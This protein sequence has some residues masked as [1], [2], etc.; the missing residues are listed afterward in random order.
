MALED[1]LS[2]IIYTVHVIIQ[3][4]II[5]SIGAQYTLHHYT[6]TLDLTGITQCSDDDSTSCTCLYGFQ[7]TLKTCAEA[8][9]STNICNVVVD[10]N[11]GSCT[12][13]QTHTEKHHSLDLVTVLVLCIMIIPLLCAPVFTI[14]TENII[15]LYY[16]YKL[17]Q[18]PM[19]TYEQEQ[20]H[21][22]DNSVEL[23]SVI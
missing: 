21:T 11:T 10:A 15:E 9:Y 7:N 2:L 22:P 8:I 16:E 12:Q 4:I 18:A 14:I 6:T 23:S 1:K 5:I 19:H 13:Y 20:V 3:E 17:K